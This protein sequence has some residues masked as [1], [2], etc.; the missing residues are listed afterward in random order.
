MGLRP[1]E[2]CSWSTA[3]AMCCRPSPAPKRYSRWNL[4]RFV[5]EVGT[6]NFVCLSERNAEGIL[7]SGGNTKQ[8]DYDVWLG[9]KIIQPWIA[10]DRHSGAANYLYL[11]GHAATQAWD[12]GAVVMYPNHV[13]LTE[14]GS[15]P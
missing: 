6:S 13:V 1:R 2:H 3:P 8:D 4:L 11:D 7:A 10:Y 5:R 15:Y 12:A 14:D 9:T